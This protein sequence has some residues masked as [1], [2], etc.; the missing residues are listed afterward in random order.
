MVIERVETIPMTAEERRR[1]V[2]AFAELIVHW[3]HTT[4]AATNAGNPGRG[5]RPGRRPG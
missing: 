2:E 5:R 4:A 3:E 1:V